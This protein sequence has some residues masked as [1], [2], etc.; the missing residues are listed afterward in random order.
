MSIHKQESDYYE[1]LAYEL[2]EGPPPENRCELYSF[3]PLLV[4]ELSSFEQEVLFLKHGRDV[5]SD[6]ITESLTNKK[7]GGDGTG[8]RENP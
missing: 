6:E 4:D 7:T 3:L 5:S 8:Y 1:N 2:F